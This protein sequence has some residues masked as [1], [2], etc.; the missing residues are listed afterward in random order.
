MGKKTESKPKLDKIKPY[1]EQ[2]YKLVASLALDFA[3]AI[4]P[5]RE[6]RYPVVHGYCCQYCGSATPEE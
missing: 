2:W 1:S 6:C 4:N 5:C 3:P